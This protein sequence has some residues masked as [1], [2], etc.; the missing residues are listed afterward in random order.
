MPVA[1][2]KSER[3]RILEKIDAFKILSTSPNRIV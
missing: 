1:N 3:L 2:T